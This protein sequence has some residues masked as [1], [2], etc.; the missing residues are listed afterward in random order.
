MANQQTLE[1]KQKV[2]NEITDKIKE[3]SSI[4]FFDYRGLKDEEITEI[5]RKLREN[6]SDMKIY[7]NTLTKR[8]LD[9]L[10]LTMEECVVGP[11]AMAFSS[12]SVSPVK[13]LDEYAKKNKSLIVKGG[14]VDGEISNLEVLS[15]LANLPSR[16][17][18]LTMLAGGMMGIVRDL[19][20]ALNMYAETKEN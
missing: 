10:K 3:S 11:S 6:N 17:A 7:K 4:I 20:I 15:Q 8:A 13:I 1:R 9:N 12:D 18:L 5:R 19:S 14:I 2:V 16:E